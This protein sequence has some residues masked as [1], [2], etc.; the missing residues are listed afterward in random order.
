MALQGLKHLTSPIFKDGQ[1]YLNRGTVCVCVANRSQCW[2]ESRTPAAPAP[3]C[4]FPP[5][6][7]CSG[8]G[9][10]G[11]TPGV[12]AGSVFLTNFP[13]C[14][15]C[16]P[17]PHLDLAVLQGPGHS[18]QHLPP[19]PHGQKHRLRFRP[20][21]GVCGSLAGAGAF[22]L[23]GKQNQTAQDDE[24]GQQPGHPGVHADPQAEPVTET[25]AV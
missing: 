23:R 6:Q 4:P 19:S 7:A 1:G 13:A 9:V 12:G 3:L 16:G 8:R 25:T 22:P 10:K 24:P 17:G 20:D 2:G 11:R 18:S 5:P 15:A 14:C 21:R